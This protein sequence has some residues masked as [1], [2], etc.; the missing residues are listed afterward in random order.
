MSIID[1]RQRM[2]L[3]DLQFSFRLDPRF[4]RGGEQ[5]WSREISLRARDWLCSMPHV[6]GSAP[7]EKEL[8]IFV[9][10][11]RDNSRGVDLVYVM[12]AS[13]DHMTETAHERNGAIAVSLIL[14]SG[15]STYDIA[16]ALAKDDVMDSLQEVLELVLAQGRLLIY[17]HP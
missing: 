4:W 16:D 14:G 17:S 8:S 3:V 12:I 13:E 7:Y 9:W 6:I 5:E 1:T 11:D 10:K 15:M 2:P